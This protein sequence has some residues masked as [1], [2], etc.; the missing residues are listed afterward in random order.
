MPFH[1]PRKTKFQDPS[2]EQDLTTPH[3][4][5]SPFPQKRH[6]RHRFSRTRK[7]TSRTPRA[8]PRISQACFTIYAFAVHHVQNQL[9]IIIVCDPEEL[10]FFMSLDRL[11]CL[12]RKM[13][14]KTG[15]VGKTNK[16]A[17]FPKGK[18]LGHRTLIF[19]GDDIVDKVTQYK[20]HDLCCIGT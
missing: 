20:G 18:C 14:V 1:S 16:S 8:K 17:R 9:C 19:G 2:F 10:R 7:Q 6:M 3:S 4:P 12:R 5:H 13:K 15:C 11:S